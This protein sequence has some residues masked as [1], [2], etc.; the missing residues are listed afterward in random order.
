MSRR[1]ITTVLVGAL[2]IASFAPKPVQAG[3]EEL[4]KFLLGAATLVI[5]GTALEQSRRDNRG[6]TI[7]Y[8]NHTSRDGVH[9]RPAP[10]PKY[11]APAPRTRARLPNYCLRRVETYKG[12]RTIYGQRCLKNNYRA[13]H[14]LPDQCRI[15][16]NG[17]RGTRLGYRP[18]CLQKAGYRR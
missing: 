11:R 10:Q 4:G 9:Y 16:V 18:G 15:R 14:A 13:A 12:P 6:D 2:A 17:P 7:I 8:R 1:F 5:I 3:N